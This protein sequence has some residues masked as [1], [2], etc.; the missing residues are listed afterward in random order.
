VK[1]LTSLL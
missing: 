1:P